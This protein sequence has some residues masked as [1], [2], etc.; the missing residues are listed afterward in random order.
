M[1]TQAP[2]RAGAAT[3]GEGPT[4]EASRV[5][6]PERWALRSIGPNPAQSDLRI[7]FAV[8]LGGGDVE[9]VVHNVEGRRVVTL[10][11]GPA[12]PGY[13]TATWDGR[14]AFGRSVSPG[15]YFVRMTSPGFT[16]TR[17]A[18]LLR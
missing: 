13:R 18:V 6:V 17:K 14:D 1:Q 12:A 5:E 15:V 9:I 8:P 2:D 10:C 11:S 7:N 3:G 4:T 16:A